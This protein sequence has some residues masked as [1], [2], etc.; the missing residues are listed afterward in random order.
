MRTE[1]KHQ[2]RKTSTAT[3]AHPPIEPVLMTVKEAAA[4]TRI[5]FLRFYE[6]IRAGHFPAG[7]VQHFG[8]A[9]RVNRRSLDEALAGP[10]LNPKRVP[11]FRGPQKKV[12]RRALQQ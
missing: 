6:L 9:I 10:D 4:Y 5:H 8:K 1:T 2:T 7:V 3:A 12:A 11:L